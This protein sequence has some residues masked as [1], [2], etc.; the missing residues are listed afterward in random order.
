MKSQTYMSTVDKYLLKHAKG[1]MITQKMLQQS[2]RLTP[3]Q[4]S[5]YVSYCIRIGLGKKTHDGL[6]LT[7]FSYTPNGDQRIRTIDKRED[8]LN[9]G[10]VR[11]KKRDTS[12]V[13]KKLAEFQP[14][15]SPPPAP[16]PY[17]PPQVYAADPVMLE[18]L[19]TV[20]AGIAQLSKQLE[21]LIKV[22][23]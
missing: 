14:P 23:A 8:A 10:R 7:A 2:C 1:E 5:R 16:K 9:Q 22:W 13:R 19:D 15:A 21:Q 20:A 4:A 18:K 12:Y 11:G 17:N 3:A 6:G